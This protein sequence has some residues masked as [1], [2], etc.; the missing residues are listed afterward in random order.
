MTTHAPGR[1]DLAPSIEAWTPRLAVASIDDLLE[2]Y[3]AAFLQRYEPHE[4]AH[5]GDRRRAMLRHFDEPDVRTFAAVGAGTLAGFAYGYRGRPGQWWHDIVTA[6]LPR[7]VSHR[8]FADCLEVVELHV[9]PEYQ[10]R[11]L[12]RLL[13]RRLLGSGAERTAALTALDRPEIP[14]RRLYAAEGFTPLLTD[15]AFPGTATRYAVLAKPLAPS[16]VPS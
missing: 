16:Q 1:L 14:A 12:G 4:A 13:L 15:F 2:V 7:D 8:W 11:G 3:R 5:L 6:A 10:H 9:R